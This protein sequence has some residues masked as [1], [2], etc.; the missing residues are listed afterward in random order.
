[1]LIPLCMAQHM[2]IAMSE[3]I[4][5]YIYSMWQLTIVYYKECVSILYLQIVI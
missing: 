3:V 4:K 2:G 5:D 1:M